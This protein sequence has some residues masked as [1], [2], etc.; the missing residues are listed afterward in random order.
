M[1]GKRIAL[2]VRV[3]VCVSGERLLLV[4]AGEEE[5]LEQGKS[6]AGNNL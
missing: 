4:G 5:P 2:Y 3:K 1:V 6:L